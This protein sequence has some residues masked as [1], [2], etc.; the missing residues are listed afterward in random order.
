MSNWMDE[1]RQRVLIAQVIGDLSPTDRDELLCWLQEIAAIRNGSLS[2]YE[3][4]K[5]S[6]KATAKSPAVVAVVKNLA[7]RLKGVVWDRR[8][9]PARIGLSAATFALVFLSQGAGIAALGGAV[10]VPLFLVFGAGG[11]LLG[12]LI[13]EVQKARR[14]DV[15]IS[16]VDPDRRW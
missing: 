10:G 7:V 6:I 5:R 15:P 1:S 4:V 13:E 2:A 9:L 3:K 8:G 11:T 16:K 14:A 12:T